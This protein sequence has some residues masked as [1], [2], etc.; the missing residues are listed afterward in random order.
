MH[1][2]TRVVLAARP[3]RH[4]ANRVIVVTALRWLA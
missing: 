3:A 2:A 4:V 1:H